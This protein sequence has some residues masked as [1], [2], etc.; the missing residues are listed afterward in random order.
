MHA[1]DLLPEDVYGF[2]STILVDTGAFD[3]GA[4]APRN[5]CAADTVADLQ[6][7]KTPGKNVLI[8]FWRPSDHLRAMIERARITD[9]PERSTTVSRANIPD[10]ET[11]AVGEL[12]RQLYRELE[13]VLTAFATIARRDAI[14]IELCKTHGRS[15]PLFHVDRVTLRLL[16]TLRGPGTEWLD[17]R[18]V[19]RK[20]LGHGDNRKIVRKG[21]LIYEVEPYQVCIL[22]GEAYLGSSGLG[23]VH[24]SPAV[25]PSI[26]GRWYLRV[27]AA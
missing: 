7:I 24:R 27:D 21:A 17:D 12:E 9:L 20:A 18:G 16:C 15:C 10:L 5:L 3:A 22:K 19:R 14:R 8:Y 26:D 13:P 2:R 25:P 1:P 4:S 11:S 23:A 6:K